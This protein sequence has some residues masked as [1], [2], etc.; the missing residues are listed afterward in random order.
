MRDLRRF[1]VAIG[2]AVVVDDGKDGTALNP[3]VWCSGA[4]T[5]RRGLVEAVRDFAM[6]PGPQSFW[7]GLWQV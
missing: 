5:K 3:R 1:F 6:L 4:V 2:R 7:A